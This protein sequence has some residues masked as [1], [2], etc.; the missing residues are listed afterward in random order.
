MNEMFLDHEVE[1]SQLRMIFVACHPALNSK[2]Q[3]A[4]ALKTIAGFNTKEIASALLV[5]EQTIKKRLFRARKTIFKQKITFD[6]PPA[7]EVK[8]R[9]LRVM[10]VIYLTF[11]EGFHSTNKNH[12]VRKDLCGEA[13][14]L[15]RLLLN[16]EALRSGALYALFALMCFHAARLESKTN[17]ENE[18]VDLQHQDRSK[19][20]WPLIVMGNDAMNKSVEYNEISM[21]QYE[22]AIAAEH[23]KARTFE[24]TNWNKILQW[25]QELNQYQPTPSTQL[26]MAIVYIQL[27]KFKSA[28]K[29]LD[30]IRTQELEQR[31][32]LLYGCYAEYYEKT[33]DLSKAASSLNKSIKLVTNELEKNHLQKK[34][35]ELITRQK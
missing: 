28:K 24:N 6:Y 29:L 5:K 33:G 32:Y 13:L 30:N 4:F 1:D 10:E 23:L 2:E 26:N 8:D 11:N 9:L 17:A 20:H 3:I 18:M 7:S 31:A 19:W 15:N 25:Y 22:A 27:S 14:R 35:A 12:L 16:K 34:K 21:Y